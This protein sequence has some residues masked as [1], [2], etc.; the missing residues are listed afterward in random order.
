MAACHGMYG[1]RSFF[2]PCF[3]C[4]VSA[5]FICIEL[6]Q[7]RPEAGKKERFTIF[8]IMWREKDMEQPIYNIKIL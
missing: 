6:R 1:R 8:G 2:I 4:C 3:D 5:F 7:H